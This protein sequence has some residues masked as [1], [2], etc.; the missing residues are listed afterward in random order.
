M[1]KNATSA[2]SWTGRVRAATMEKFEPEDLLPDHQPAYVASW[3]YIFGVATLAALIMLVASG[4]YL[5]LEGPAW[6][7]TSRVGHYVN[8]VHLWS[9]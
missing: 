8:S 7:H 1:S 4:L 3:I 9:V 2:K 6:W 5:T